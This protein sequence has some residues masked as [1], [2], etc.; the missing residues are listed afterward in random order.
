MVTGV[1]T[2]LF[3]SYY[4]LY[5]LCCCL[6]IKL[7]SSFSNQCRATC[8]KYLFIHLYPS[9]IQLSFGSIYL[10]GGYERTETGRESEL[11]YYISGS[12]YLYIIDSP[13]QISVFLIYGINVVFRWVDACNGGIIVVP[14]S[15]VYAYFYRFVR[16]RSEERRV[17]KECRSRWSPYH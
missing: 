9:Y 4:F 13:Y 3:R 7:I 8:I 16:S 10:I 2:W 17:G 11:R 5:F 1:Q 6:T 14:T 12:E 15:I